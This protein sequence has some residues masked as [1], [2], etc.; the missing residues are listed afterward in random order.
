MQDIIKTTWRTND[1][2]PTQQALLI[3]KR[4]DE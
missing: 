2:R 3:E 4:L 1:G